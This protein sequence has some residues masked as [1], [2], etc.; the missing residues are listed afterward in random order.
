MDYRLYIHV[1]AL[2]VSV[3]GFRVVVVYAMGLSVVEIAA[4]VYASTISIIC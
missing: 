4:L 2:L 1:Y 3:V